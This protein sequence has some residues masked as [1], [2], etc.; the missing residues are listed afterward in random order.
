MRRN[1]FERDHDDFRQLIRDFIERE[2]SPYFEKWITAGVV[3]RELYTKLGEIGAMGFAIPEEYGGGGRDDYRYN[4]VLQEE[5]ARANVTLG[6]FRTHLDVALPYL[7]KY[8]NDEQRARW[9]PGLASGELFLAIAMTEPGTGSDLA[10]EDHGQA[11]RRRVR[12]QRREDV[13]HRRRTRRSCRGVGAHYQRRRRQSAKRPEPDRGPGWHPWVRQG[14][15][16]GQDRHEGAGHP[17]AVVH[18]RA[19]ARDE[20]AR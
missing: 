9:F 6:T 17:G 14:A 18:R 15:P 11:R 13:H 8:A 3:P 16:A 12:H 2:V 19:G 5:C 1:L 7:L 20:P 10:G 4:T